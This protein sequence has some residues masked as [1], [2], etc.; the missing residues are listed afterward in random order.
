MHV[1]HHHHH[2]VRVP[3]DVQDRSESGL[4]NALVKCVTTFSG[5]PSQ[6]KR[7]KGDDYNSKHTGNA[8]GMRHSAGTY[9]SGVLDLYHT[10]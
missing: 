4:P 2:H 6:K 8:S 5:K 3:H 7:V 10:V 9:E 1:L